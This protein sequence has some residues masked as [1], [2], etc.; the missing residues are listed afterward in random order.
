MSLL[1]YPFVGRTTGRVVL[2]CPLPLL[3]I[4][5]KVNRDSK[6]SKGNG[7][8]KLFSTYTIRKWLVIDRKSFQTYTFLDE[9]VS[10]L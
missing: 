6:I 1:T 7:R 4:I 8:C 10:I 9:D 5:I 2:W 3:N